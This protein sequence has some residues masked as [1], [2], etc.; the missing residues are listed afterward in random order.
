M[1]STTLKN[2]EDLWGTHEGQHG[3]LI[4]A[5][6]SLDLYGGQEAL[7]ERL[8]VY[9]VL[10]GMNETIIMVRTLD[11]L[12]CFDYKAARKTWPHWSPDLK[13]IIDNG[14]GRHQL[15]PANNNTYGCPRL[16]HARAG[17]L[18]MALS[19]CRELGIKKLDLWGVDLCWNTKDALQ[20]KYAKEIIKKL[21]GNVYGG[22]SIHRC[23]NARN[24]FCDQAFERFVIE[25]RRFKHEWEDMEILNRSP[26]SQLDVFPDGAGMNGMKP[27]EA[28][29]GAHPGA[30]AALIG[31]GPSL[32]LRPPP[33]ARARR[34]R[35]S[36]RHE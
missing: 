32:D 18:G 36:D 28:L 21:G 26:I 33:R 15:S 23:D 7:E 14:Y 13:V 6:P 11:Y 22:S 19:F 27:M 31:P 29:E 10:V 5:G 25:I 8:S 4:G 30:R 2:A 9:D 16:T 20:N 24:L 35:P 17:S 12:T 34:L 3:A 1:K